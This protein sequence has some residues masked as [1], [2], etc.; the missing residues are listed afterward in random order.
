MRLPTRLLLAAAAFATVVILPHLAGVGTAGATT[1]LGLARELGQGSLLAYAVAFAGG[2]LTSLTP[3]VYP[4]IPITVSIFG[5]KKAGSR[6]QAMVLSGLYVLGIAVM[7]SALGLVA[8]LSGAAFGQAMQSPWVLRA[9]AL[10]FAAMGLSMLGLFELQLPPAL[11]MR[12]NRV[13]GAGNAGAFAMG[14]VSGIVAAPCTGPVLAAALAYIASQGSVVLGVSVMFAYALGLGL[15]FFLIGAFSLSLPKSGRWM[16]VVKSV[17]GVAL[18]VAALAFLQRTVPGL[19][20][21]VS[22]G[23]APLLVA[24][25]AAAAGVLL[26]ALTRSFG[27]RRTDAAWKAAG[28]VLVVAALT[29]SLGVAGAR[30]RVRAAGFAW[31]HDYEAAV[32]TARAEGRPMIID[33]WA[34]W[35]E[36][37]QAL[38]HGAWADLS[39]RAEAE[40]F[41]KVKVDGS[42][43]TPEFEAAVSR[44]GVQG[45]PTVVFLDARGREVPQRVMGAVPPAEMLATLRAIDHACDDR[46]PPEAAVACVLRW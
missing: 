14:L 44:Y 43:D 8:A 31:G 34:D 1:D 46:K 20:A 16:E 25:G 18:L 19:G 5:A 37:C 33:F 32:R 41:V 17:F 42:K 2:V 21:L 10:V 27:E 36:A 30:D 26:G 11:A 22:A 9:V 24:A 39:V 38:D 40:R 12:L 7:Y 15:L 35:C 3:C 28:L 4:L 13:G 6:G 45:L 29:W 23:R